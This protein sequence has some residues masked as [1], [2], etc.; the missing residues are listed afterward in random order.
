LL[1]PIDLNLAECGHVAAR[2]ID[3]APAT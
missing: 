3:L 1:R 2:L